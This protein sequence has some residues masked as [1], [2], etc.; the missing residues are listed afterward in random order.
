MAKFCPIS[1][2]LLAIG[3]RL[4]HDELVT[5]AGAGLDPSAGVDDLVEHLAASTALTPGTARR[6]V[7]EVVVFLSETVEEFVRRRH[8]ELQAGGLT[9]PEIFSRLDEELAGRRFRAPLLS[10]RQLRRIVYG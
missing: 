8:R 1:G 5:G 10:S 7:E 4:V 9:N 6:L 2:R 3:S